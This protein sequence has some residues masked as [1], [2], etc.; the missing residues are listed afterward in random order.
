MVYLPIPLKI[1]I[2]D[3]HINLLA[4]QPACFIN[5]LNPIKIDHVMYVY[6]VIERRGNQ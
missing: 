5:K 4:N 3:A 6:H 2:Y 1:L